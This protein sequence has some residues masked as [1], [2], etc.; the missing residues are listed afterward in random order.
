MFGMGDDDGDQE[1]KDMILQSL[2]EKM[3]DVLGERMGSGDGGL[4]LNDPD[5]D[6][7]DD[8]QDPGMAVKVIADSPE[9][10]AEGLHQAKQVVEN[11]QAAGLKG[12]LGSQQGEDDDNDGKSD[13]ERLAELLGDDDDEEDDDD[14]LNGRKGRL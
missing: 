11:P 3:E 6:G 4:G 8:S 1:L 2:I 13:V 10:L 7:D 14:E 9:S 12:L 5:G